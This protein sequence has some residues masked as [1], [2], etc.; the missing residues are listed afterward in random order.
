M[1][2]EK[3]IEFSQPLS[4]L[5]RVRIHFAIARFAWR[6]L[7]SHKAENVSIRFVVNKD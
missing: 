3:I 2:E 7:W 4:R 6:W 5:D 1:P